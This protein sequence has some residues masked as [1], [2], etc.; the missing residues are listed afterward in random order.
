VN[1]HGVP[2][3]SIPKRAIMAR[4]ETACQIN[5]ISMTSIS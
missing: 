3:I 1:N 5:R 2:R 4:V